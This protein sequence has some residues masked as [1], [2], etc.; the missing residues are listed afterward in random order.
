MKKLSGVLLSMSVAACA[1]WPNRPPPI[2]PS[3]PP[4]EPVRVTAPVECTLPGE[5]PP[6]FVEPVLP[7]DPPQG[8]PALVVK[9]AQIAQLQAGFRHLKVYSADMRKWGA[10]R[11]DRDVRCAE[12]NAGLNK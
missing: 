12:F 6:Q 3:L 11:Y 10:D 5:P 8:A 9:D 1:S 4:P 2:A 7:P